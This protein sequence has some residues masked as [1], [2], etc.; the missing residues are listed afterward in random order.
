MTQPAASEPVVHDVSTGLQARASGPA[1]PHFTVESP[2]NLLCSIL[3]LDLVG[4]S[5]RTLDDQVAIKERLND[6]VTRV[7]QG[8]AAD[9]R[10]TID[11]GDGA[12]I[13]FLAD[14]EEALRS[15]LLLRDRVRAHEGVTLPV[16]IGLHIGPVRVVPDI[17]DRINVV[18]DGINVA[19]RIMDFAQAGQ[20]LASRAYYDVISRI[21]DTAAELFRPEG[22]HRDKT[23][24]LHE[25][26]S[27]H[28]GSRRACEPVRPY[29][30][31]LTRADTALQ[32][33][34]SALDGLQA[35]LARHL[36]PVASL[37]VTQALV[38]C[39]DA[40]TLLDRLASH[41]EPAAHRQTF[42]HA[43][44]RCLAQAPGTALNRPGVPPL[45]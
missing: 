16:R 30:L 2:R 22:D 28:D 41:V 3:F 23:G 26:H 25:L 42:R 18:G 31:A 36:G 15:A 20:I 17:N 6:L 39:D 9:S 10:L 35:A 24:R 38:G 34:A 27:V 21:A 32:V 14:P 8:A 19:Q 44:R 43:A 37:L 29:S 7:A 5:S 4:Y 33:D 45:P 11:T 13:C 1:L 12:A 40:E